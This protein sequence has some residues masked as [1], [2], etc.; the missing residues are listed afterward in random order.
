MTTI[1]S[2]N[3]CGSVTVCQVFGFDWLTETVPYTVRSD[4][5]TQGNETIPASVPSKAVTTTS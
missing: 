1:G 3:A 4:D 2:W 5:T